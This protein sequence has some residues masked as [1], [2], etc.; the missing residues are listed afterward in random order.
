MSSESA[1]PESWEKR[2]AEA[3][4]PCERCAALCGLLSKEDQGRL[5][6]IARQRTI[7]RGGTIFRAHEA[8]PYFAAIIS[9][10]VKLCRVLPDGRQQI[11]GLLFPS[12][13]LGR[14]FHARNHFFAAAATD[15]RLCCFDKRRFE[16]AIRDCPGLVF[17]LFERS[18]DELDAA[19]EWMLLL[20]RKTAE[21]RVASFLLLAAHRCS[22]L[23]WSARSDSGPVRFNLPVSRTDIADFLG[24]TLSTVSRQIAQL[25]ARGIVRAE[26]GRGVVIEDIRGL[27]QV[28]GDCLQV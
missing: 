28:S 10:V 15:V 23:N 20:G 16:A 18:L 27:L 25:E 4:V 9:G 8:P 17:R 11:V 13:F 3:R 14:P 19:H 24:V 1:F 22:P 7:A 26:A 6:Q 5:S 12:D 21:E 2:E